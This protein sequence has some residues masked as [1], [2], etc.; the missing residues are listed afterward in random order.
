MFG[1]EDVRSVVRAVE[2]HH[3]WLKKCLPMIAS[4][5]VTSPAVREMLVTD[6]GHRYAE[7][8]P[9]ERL[10]EGCE[11]IDEVELACV[12]LAKELFGAEHANVQPTSGVV[13]NLAA[14]FALT[15]PGDTILGLRISHGGHISHHDISAPGV[16][17][18]N[19]EY[20][21]FDEE[22]MAID[23]DGMVRKIEEV[24]PSV[25]MLGASLFLFPHPVE[26][27]VEAAEA[28]GGYVVYDAAHVLGLIAG[29]QFQDPIREGAH[30]VT[31]S[32]HKTFPGPQGG[33]VLCRRDLADD[34]DEAV[35]PGLVSN[36]HLHHVAALAVALAEF[37]E[38][39]ERYARDTVRNAKALAEALYA[40]GLQVLCEHRGFTESHQIAVDVR[41]HGGGATVA[42]KLESANILC[43]KN[44]LPWDDES[45]SH[46]PSG[47]RLGTQELTRLGMGPSE[48]EYIAE[49]IADVVLGRREPSE[50][51]RDVEELRREFQEVKYGFGSGVGAHEWP[52]LADW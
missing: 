17:G 5:N 28:V 27:A 6:F 40:E 15:E 48:M 31:G 30:V 51:R 25:V 49:L 46:D 36:H 35:F 21:P 50:V 41:E 12:R 47:I 1:L 4:E 44:L 11:Y 39:G 10:Y 13:A 29:G 34:I 16:R 24:E 3:E 52:R 43:N 19:V 37:K 22:D 18:L 33:I 45:K 42:E 9:G 32:T 7:G 20:L 2:E 8:K 38:Y 23:V 26:E 14:L